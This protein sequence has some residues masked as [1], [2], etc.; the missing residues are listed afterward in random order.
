MGQRAAEPTDQTN[1]DEAEKDEDKAVGG[2]GKEGAR[3]AHAAHVGPGDEGDGQQTELHP[4]G[5]QGRKGRGKGRDAGRDAHGHGEHIVDQQGGSRRQTGP[6]PQ[7]VVGDD[8]G[9]TAGGIAVDGLEIGTGDDGQQGDDGQGN[10]QRELHRGR[11]GHDQDQQD[12]FGGV[13][14]G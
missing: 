5:E 12:L 14:H 8:V 9:S 2:D 11:P 10:G 7:V 13:G 4:V 1:G 6:D 3:F